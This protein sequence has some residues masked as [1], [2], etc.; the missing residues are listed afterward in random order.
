MIARHAG[1]SAASLALLLCLLTLARPLSAAT[2]SPPRGSVAPAINL[3]DLSGQIVSTA[4]L[5]PR[6]LVLIFGDLNHDGAKR[7][8]ADVLDVLAEPRL[9]GV[10]AVP[11]LIVA[12]DLPAAQLKEQAAQGRFPAIILN[13][14]RRDAFGAYRV[15]VIPTVVIVDGQGKVVHS[16]PAFLQNSREVLAQALLMAAGKETA[17]QFERAIE[18]NAAE[19]PHEQVRADRLVHLAVELTR[20]GLYDMAEGRYKEATE[21]APGH[22]GATLGLGDL[23]LRQNRLDDAEALFRSVLAAHA[24]SADAALGLA[25]VQTRR[26]GDDLAKAEA[27]LKAILAKEPGQPRARYL[28]GQIL[29]RRGDCPGALAEY[30]K[31]AELLMER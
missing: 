10:A 20:H 21:L 19:V 4:K 22:V 23:M 12:Q 24:D 27:S 11:I 2:A 30:R 3:P 31:A 7:A 14:P 18:P 25:S 13:D 1:R 15:L 26:G 9:A 6:S 16:L 5:A 28:M 29:E 17:E 8:C